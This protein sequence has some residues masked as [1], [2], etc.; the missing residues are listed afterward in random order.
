V[1]AY[2]DGEMVGH[3]L[4]QPED[5]GVVHL[6][7]ISVANDHQRRGIGSGLLT[8]FEACAAALGVS[9]VTLGSA[10]GYVDRFY[11]ERGYEPESILVRLPPDD[12]P[13]NY[14]DLGYEIVEER[15]AEGVQ[16]L[17][18]GVDELDHAEVEG[19]RETFGDEEAIYIMEKDLETPPG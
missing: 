4:G 19:V 5:D 8:E 15:M 12:V 16:K 14:R 10:G 9:R 13:E 18:V 6:A 1:G 7:G 17:Y 2:V 11:R 3:C